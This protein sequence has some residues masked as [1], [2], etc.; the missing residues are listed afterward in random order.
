[1]KNKIIAICLFTL[2]LAGCGGGSGTTTPAAAAPPSVIPPV[3]PSTPPVTPTM[4]PPA[5]VGTNFYVAPSG[6][7]M[8]SGTLTLPWKTL[9]KAVNTVGAGSIINARSGIYTEQVVFA[10]SGSAGGGYITLQN[11]P[12]ETA[13]IDGTGIVLSAIG[14]SA[15]V[16]LT[17]VSFIRVSGLEIRNLSTN[18]A[19]VVPTGIFVSGSGNNIELSNNYVH[20]IVTTVNSVAGNAFGIAIYGTGAPASINNLIIYGN[21]VAHLQTGSSESVSVNGNVENFQV[22]NNKVHDN[23]NIGIGFIGFEG[24]SS[25]P[26]Y[27]QARNG[28]VAGNVVY[29]ISSYGNPAYGSASYGADGLYVDG[30][31]NIVMERNIVYQTDIGI[32]VASEHAG[33]VG[34]FV[35]LRSNL[36][37]NNNLTGISLGGTDAIKNGGSDSCGIFNNTLFQNDSTGSGTGEIA[38]QNNLTNIQFAN[39][40]ISSRAQGIFI[41]GVSSAQPAMNGDLYFSGSATGTWGWKGATYTNLAAF[42]AASGNE[43]HGLVADPL[44]ISPNTGNFKLNAGSP[45]INAGIALTTAQIGT[46]DLAGNSRVQS[47]GIDIGAY[48]H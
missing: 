3:T 41:S 17:N 26:A 16:S 8:N 4:P 45:A 32:E 13:V 30:G 9:Q 43:V 40:V 25:D 46:M 28:L 21:E 6:S 1:M 29:N 20:D 47:T 24:T 7:D 5:A 37:Y 27:D 31:K 39:N 11:Y 18:S 48:E 33:H 35:T 23:N 44:L 22:M 34:S 19:S 12:G 15:L 42:T 38:L 36:I 2:V 10:N 14:H